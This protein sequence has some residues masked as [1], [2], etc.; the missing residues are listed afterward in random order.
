[1]PDIVAVAAI[2]TYFQLESD[3]ASGTYATVAGIRNVDGPSMAAT[4]QDITTHSQ[5]D[6]WRRKLPTL[7]DAGQMT[8]EMVFNPVDPTQDHTAGV[9]S[10]FEN[11]TLKNARV[12]FPDA[13]LTRWL[14]SGYIIKFGIKA[15]VDG[16]L[17]SDCA[18]DISGKPTFAG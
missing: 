14:A 3:S 13:A 8:F 2:N 17:M 5:S 16:V 12:Q 15:A 4:V 6:Y 11:R 7:L 1:M 9:L 10:Y 18:F